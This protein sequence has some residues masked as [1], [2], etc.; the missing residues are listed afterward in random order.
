MA[1][2]KLLTVV[3]KNNKVLKNNNPDETTARKS[4]KDVFDA[5]NYVTFKN[6]Q[7]KATSIFF[8]AENNCPEFKVELEVKHHSENRSQSY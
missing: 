8:V 1:H 7:A 5:M 3:V 4:K 6:E 2:G